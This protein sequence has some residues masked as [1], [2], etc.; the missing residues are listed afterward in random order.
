MN[1]LLTPEIRQV[2]GALHY[3]PS[4]SIMIPFE[5]KTNS[6]TE[7]ILSLKLIAESAEKE[8]LENYPVE[9]CAVITEK[10]R[11]IIRNLSFNTNKKSIAI[12]VSLVFEKVIYLDTTVNEK[13]TIDDSFEI[14]DLVY[15]KK[16]IEKYLLL[17]F[18]DKKSEVFLINSSKF[19]RVVPHA[20]ELIYAYTNDITKNDGPPSQFEFTDRVLHHMDQSLDEITLAYPLPVF[21]MGTDDIVDHFKK[22]TKHAAS[23]VDYVQGNYEYATFTELKAA[24]KPHIVSWHKQQKD[25]LLA[26][27]QT[28]NAKN[29]LITG[30]KNVW[31]EINHHK[32]RLL[33][34]EKNFRYLEDHQVAGR[35]TAQASQTGER[36]IYDRDSVD[37]M[38]EK[39]LENGGD[40]EFVNDGDLDTY[41]HIALV[42]YY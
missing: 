23:I 6:K 16:Q 40:V 1:T 9:V 4:V 36:T 35:T 19:F 11:K 28:E 2:I 13:I 31:A 8:L 41:H 3:R 5:P 12:Y 37:D 42:Q 27:L 33:V 17:L 29:K 34:V 30:V 38:I 7:L 22:I 10:L 18:T 32:G 20:P 24:L 21:I 26:K 14:R 25:H 39:V 15:N